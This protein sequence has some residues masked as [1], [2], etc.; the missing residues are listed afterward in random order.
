MYVWFLVR[1]MILMMGM[2]RMYKKKYLFLPQDI[3][4]VIVNITLYS[5]EIEGRNGTG[6]KKFWL[7][8]VMKRN[9]K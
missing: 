7:S 2:I 6:I 9:W 4:A 3:V 8:I 1:G 5:S